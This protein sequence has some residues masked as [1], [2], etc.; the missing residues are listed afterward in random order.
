MSKPDNWTSHT[1]LSL[2][3]RCEMAWKLRYVDGIRGEASDAMR[4]GTL[5]H[6]AAGAINRGGDW[7]RALAEKIAED[8]AD[9]NLVDVDSLDEI[10]GA[11][12]PAKAAWLA[13]RYEEH[14]AEERSTIEVVHT[15]LDLTADLPDTGQVH[16]AII[17]EVWRDAAGDLWVVERKTYGRG[18]RITYVEVDPQLTNNLWVARANGIDAVGIVWDGIY[19]YRWKPEKPTQ[20]ALIEAGGWPDEL[21][22]KAAIQAWA[23][24]EVAK[25]PGI[26][27]PPSES[28]TRF[29]LDRTDEHLAAAQQDIGASVRRRAEL[30]A[31]EQ[32]VRNIGSDCDWCSQ[33]T[34]CW[35]MLAFPQSFELDAD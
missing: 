17:D 22:T 28:F 32:P 9:A 29:W 30:R 35:E 8:G 12:V 31:G 7:R 19:T 6:I 20:K 21:T 11:E 10:E 2:L 26:E 25:H 24:A 34:V 16:Q 18:D 33:R 13:K 27:R 3:A 15:E 1:E 23:K 4:L 14:Y 5:V